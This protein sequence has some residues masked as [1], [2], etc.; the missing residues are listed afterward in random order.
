MLTFENFNNLTPCKEQRKKSELSQQE[1]GRTQY[2]LAS[3]VWW[4][5][6][7]RPSRGKQRPAWV[8]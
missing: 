8:T 7:R 4:G 2:T 3:L 6:H 5:T 1:E